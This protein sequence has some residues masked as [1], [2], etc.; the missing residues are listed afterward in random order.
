MARTKGVDFFR[1]VALGF[2][3]TL[4]LNTTSLYTQ[5]FRVHSLSNNN[6]QF[7]IGDVDINNQAEPLLPGAHFEYSQGNERDLWW[8]LSNIYAVGDNIGDVIV[9]TYEK[10][11]ES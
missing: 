2:G 4:V 5:S 9:V 1:K 10:Y 8:D 11:I 7:Y 3:E 6:G